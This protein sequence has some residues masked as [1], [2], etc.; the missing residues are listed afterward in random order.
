ML[1][2]F[3]TLFFVF[4][5]LVTNDK[6]H[7][8]TLLPYYFRQIRYYVKIQVKK[9]KKIPT[10]SKCIIFLMKRDQRRPL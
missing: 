5:T 10:T 3:E 7:R 8:L 1:N 6:P 2:I 4:S 9:E